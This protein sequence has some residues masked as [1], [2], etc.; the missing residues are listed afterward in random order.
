MCLAW[1][2]W[3]DKLESGGWRRVDVQDGVFGG[4]GKSRVREVMRRLWFD[5]VNVA[6]VARDDGAGEEQG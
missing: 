4:E 5:E 3:L 1:N 2:R 6:D